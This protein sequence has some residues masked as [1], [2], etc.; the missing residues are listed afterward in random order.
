MVM[1]LQWG[2]EG[3]G[4]VVDWIAERADAVVRFNGGPNAGH[5]IPLRGGGRVSVHQL[6]SGVVNP[7]ATLCMGRGMV[8]DVEKLVREIAETRVDPE[9]I[10]LDPGAHVICP[11]HINDDIRTEEIRG[12]KAIGT[13]KSGNGPAYAD[14]YAR[15]G[16]R[17]GDLLDGHDMDDAVHRITDTHLTRAH[18]DM[19]GWA[20]DMGDLIQRSG[21]QISDVSSLL[22]ASHMAH[23]RL[24]FECAHG[25]ELDID[26]GDYPYVTSS[27]CGLGGVYSGAGFS[28][29][30]IGHVIGVIKP[31]STRVGAGSFTMPMPPDV[32]SHIREAGGEYGVTTGRPRKIG[33][34]DLQRLVRA[35]RM[36][37]VSRLALTHQDMAQFLERV[38]YIGVGGDV[39]GVD[40]WSLTGVIES[41]L[42]MPIQYISDGPQHQCMNQLFG[43]EGSDA[44]V[45][46][47]R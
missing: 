22:T 34:L 32:E 42:G 47:V 14:K 19:I 33:V 28:P 31:Y 9:R 17:V 24:L 45:W 25:F 18:K 12:S 2:D 7:D 44:S 35:C 16:M 23:K 6:P 46:Q 1:G 43:E 8:I 11:C 10:V 40:W 29:K 30:W 3:K 37:S 38:V 15:V 21:I 13:T 20:Y 4:R 5:T 39:R 27:S 36:N 41:S 26:H